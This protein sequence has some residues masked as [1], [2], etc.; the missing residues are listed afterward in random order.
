MNVLIVGL[1]LMGGAYAY[2]LSL[3]GYDV[4]GVDNNLDSINYALKNNYIKEGSNNAKDFIVKSDLII[5]ALYPNQIIEFLKNNKELFKKG[6][7]ITDISGVK[8]SFVKEAT[9][10]AK[11]AIYL[12]HHPMAGKEKSGIEYSYL[13]NFNDANFL[14]TPLDEK[15]NIAIPEIKQLGIDLGFKKITVIDIERHD[16]MIGFT[17]QLMH[18]IAVALVNSDHDPDTKNFI[19]DSYRDLTRVAMINENLWS[20][21][22]ME[23]KDNLLL[24]INSFELELDMIKKALYENDTETLKKYFRDS[25]KHRKEMEK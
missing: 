13:V 5:L 24:H 11:P 10:I 14:I 20:C 19:G 4:Y 22:F 2:R 16:K 12:S 7:I 23:N 17:S 18:A 1:G 8:T 25:T 3:K 15:E 9:E 6:Q 21:L